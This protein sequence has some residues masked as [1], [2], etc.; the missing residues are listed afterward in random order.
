MG[1]FNDL[2]KLDDEHRATTRP[3]RASRRARVSASPPAERSATA[4]AGTTTTAVPRSQPAAE[5]VAPAAAP[6]APTPPD[7]ATSSPSLPSPPAHP[8]GP[9]L[10]LSEMPYRKFTC[11]LTPAEHRALDLLK[12]ELSEAL[13]GP[14]TKEQLARCAIHYLVADVRRLGDASPVITPLKAKAGSR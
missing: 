2:H 1:M 12:I 4:D 11:L 9:S 6:A 3:K 10:D 7:A 5:P 13:D 8:A 14:I